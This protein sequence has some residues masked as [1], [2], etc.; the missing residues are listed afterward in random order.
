[1]ANKLTLLIVARPGRIRDGLRTLLK[2][3]PQIKRIDQVDNT[4]AA[5]RIMAELHPPLVLLGTDQS[6]ESIDTISRQAKIGDPPSRCV[7]LVDTVEHRTLATAAGVDQVLLAGVT[8]T[9]FLAAVEQ[10]LMKPASSPPFSL[11]ETISCP[12]DA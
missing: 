5:L 2:T 7:V 6:Q 10:L 4:P 9:E 11:L 1:M 12:T 8:T 3:M